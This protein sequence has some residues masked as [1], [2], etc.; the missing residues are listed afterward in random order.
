MRPT[1]TLLATLVS[2]SATAG[3]QTN[4][5]LSVSTAGGQSDAIS[6]YTSM[7]RDGRYVTW[8][9]A[10]TNLV[11][12]DTNGAPDVYV[13][14][15]V[16][17]T[18][19]R[20]S[21]D[22]AGVEGN[23]N[24]HD[25]VISSDGR[26]VAFFS[27]ATNFTAN[28]TNAAPDC[29]VHDLATGATT[30]VS[31]TPAGVPG[32]GGSRYPAFSGDVRYVAFHSVATDFGPIDANGKRDIYVRDLA[33]GAMELVSVATDGSQS[34][35]DCS[36]PVLSHDGRFVVFESFATNLAPGDTNGTLDIYAR[37]RLAGITL[38]V[39]VSTVGAGADGYSQLP[40]VTADGRFVVFNSEATNLVAGDTNSFADVFVRDLVLGLTERVSVTSAGGQSNGYSYDAS[41]SAD[42]R[43]VAFPS[44]GINI[45]PGDVNG[46]FDIFL[47]DRLTGTTEI[48]TTGFAGDA[49]DGQALYPSI[50]NDGRFI[51]YDG[52]STNLVPGDVNGQRDIFL[53]DRGAQAEHFFVYCF[54]DGAANA[55]PCPCGNAGGSGRGCAN[56]VE[57]SG[58]RLAV[59]G[60]PS[61]ANDTVVL[62]AEGMPNSS[63][64][65]FQGSLR[66]SGGIGVAF[67]DGL[68]CVGG[69][70]FRL[71]TKTNASNASQF[72]EV[73]DASVSVR[74]GIQAGDVRTYQVWYR[75]A[76]VFC[77]MSTFNLTNGVQVVWGS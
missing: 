9:S 71:G 29:F 54:G 41:I 42:G 51:A 70:I 55:T 5:L 69:T 59:S 52:A 28:D 10:A 46:V 31:A 22:S 47:H 57:A 48:V 39:S 67:G 26:L 40:N 25:P 35:G 37:D 21:V 24:S 63:A 75:N 32:N 76:A 19:V 7:S 61:V 15:R 43:W 50:S 72:P 3:A 14:D 64:L 18:T 65:Y 38:R 56:S 6:L 73:G 17:S 8:Q 27:Y 1:P 34:D 16:A 68:R 30:L 4:E 36:N 49:A 2:L 20:V 60:A 44:R 13:R 23:G 62:A 45:V 74:G 53:R 12:N 11:P 77:M 33:T 66:Q 58:A